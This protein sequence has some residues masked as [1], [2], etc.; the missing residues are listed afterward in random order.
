MQDSKDWWQLNVHKDIHSMVIHE[1]K[2]KTKQCLQQWLQ[3]SIEM[4]SDWMMVAIC[5]TSQV[6]I[7]RL[8]FGSGS[9]DKQHDVLWIHIIHQILSQTIA[10]SCTNIQCTCQSSIKT[11]RNVQL[12][13]YYISIHFH[14]LW[15][16]SSER[17]LNVFVYSW[18][19]PCLT[20]HFNR[21]LSVTCPLIHNL[22]GTSE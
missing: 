13:K 2:K 17:A 22:V 1:I 9:V 7:G 6:R 12:R 16:S 20:P 14:A 4:S 11:K 8:T 5:T 18:Q 19:Y 10:I 15:W 21:M 3:S